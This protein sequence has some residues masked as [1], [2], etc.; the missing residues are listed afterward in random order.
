MTGLEAVRWADTLAP[1]AYTT[2]QKIAWLSDLD[3]KLYREFLSRYAGVDDDPPEPYTDGSEELLIPFPYARDVYGNWL[4]AKIAEA[5]QEITLYNLHSTL[6][7]NEFKGFCELYN[8]DH[9]YK[10]SEAGRSWI[11]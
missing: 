10:G 4:L 6:F 5:N 8:R 9:E 7:N 2:E 11:F 1:N 3:G